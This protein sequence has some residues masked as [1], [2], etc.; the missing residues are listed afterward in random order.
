MKINPEDVKVPL[1][2]NNFINAAESNKNINV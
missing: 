2:K 1:E